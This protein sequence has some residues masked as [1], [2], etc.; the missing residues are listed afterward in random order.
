MKKHI[1]FDID[2]TLLNTTEALLRSMQAALETVTGRPFDR[3]SLG[4]YMGITGEDALNQIGVT[5]VQGT[6]H[7]WEERLAEEAWR[8]TVY[9]GI[10]ELLQELHSR[11]YHLGMVTSKDQ[12]ELDMDWDR[13]PQNHLFE[14][15]VNADDT[16]EHKP[17][18][19]PLLKYLERAGIAPE[20]ALYIGDSQHDMLC[21]R[22]AGVDFV[23]AVWGAYNRNLD[24]QTVLEQPGDLLQY[25]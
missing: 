21:A 15:I 8:T 23:L 14:L 3:E 5:D 20:E 9:D 17:S 24:V 6:L 4:I 12:K 18:P 16:K 10:P 22:K 2:G 19:E 13:I 1:I 7:L 25:L 11:G